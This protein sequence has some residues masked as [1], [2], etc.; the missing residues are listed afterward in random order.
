MIISNDVEKALDKIQHPFIIKTLNKLGI[1]GNCVNILKTI[2]EKSTANIIL[3]GERLK[4]FLKS[5]RRQGYSFPKLSES[6]VFL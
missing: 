6:R 4:T 2:Y 1:E 3:S 5:G